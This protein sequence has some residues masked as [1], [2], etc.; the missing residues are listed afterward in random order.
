L[1]LAYNAPHTPLQAT[2]E[3]YDALPFIT[4]QTLRVYAAMIRSLDRNIGR[5]LQALR[6]QGVEQNTLVIFTSDNGAPHYIDLRDRNAPLR[7]WKATYFEGG[8]RVPLLMRWPAGLPADRRVSG[9]AAHFDIFAT[10]AAAAGQP[11]PTDRPIDGVDLLPFARGTATTPSPHERLF[12]RTED[13]LTMREG[14]WKLQVTQR[15]R[16]DWLYDL[17]TDP[18]ERSNLA[19]REPDRVVD[20]KAAINRFNAEQAK[21]IW[22]SLGSAY[23][24]IDKILADPPAADDEYVYFAN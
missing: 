15:P 14:P 20:M 16:K 12:W 5:V 1:D 18:G 19:A 9:M 22:E 4:D 24:P 17:A 3:D 13:Y 2:R 6:D 11:V 21:P 10:I 7:G 8:I 23:V